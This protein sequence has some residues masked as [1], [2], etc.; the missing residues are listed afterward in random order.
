MKD[1]HYS[2]NLIYIEKL[3]NTYRDRITC[4]NSIVVSKNILEYAEESQIF[5]IHKVVNT[6]YQDYFVLRK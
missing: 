6:D 5:Q 2:F 3:D 4:I 1:I